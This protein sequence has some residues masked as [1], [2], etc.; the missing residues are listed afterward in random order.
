MRQRALTDRRIRLD[1]LLLALPVAFLAAILVLPL[2]SMVVASL[3]SDEPLGHFR[4]LAGDGVFLRSFVRTMRVCLLVTVVC[5]VLGLPIAYEITRPQT[6]RRRFL[7]GGILLSF[8]ISILVRTY[9]WV[10]ILQ[11]TGVVNTLLRDHAGL[12]EPLPLL[13]NEFGIVVGMVHVLL[14]FMVMAL[15]PAIRS[16]NPRLVQAAHNLG[17]NRSQTFLRVILPLSSGGVVAGSL[18]VFILGLAFFITPA[19]LGGPADVFVSQLIEREVGRRQE[20]GLASAMGVVLTVAVGA[21]YLGFVKLF[22]PTR[23]LGGGGR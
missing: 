3:S 11:N 16:V 18:L 9:S 2:I 10:L 23:Y 17:A 20:F 6:L 14:P 19:I 12:K 13:R 5:L 1:W 4:Q 22:D 21:I 7:L 8:W 15:I